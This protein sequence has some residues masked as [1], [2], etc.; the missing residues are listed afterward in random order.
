MV[1]AELLKLRRSMVWAFVPLLSLLAVISGG[2]NYWMNRDVLDNGWV[3]LIGQTTL[4]YGIIF[5]AVGIGL[6]AC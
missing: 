2:I 1:R 5:Y 4:F 3:S 6:I